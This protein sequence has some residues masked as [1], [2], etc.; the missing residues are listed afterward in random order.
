MD[1]FG[2]ADHGRRAAGAETFHVV[3]RKLAVVG[4]FAVVDAELLFQMVHALVGPAQHAGHV[5]ADLDVIVALRLLVEHI[6]E[7]HDAADFGRLQLQHFGQF[8]LR[9]DRAIAEF[10]LDHIEC[11]QDRR[12]L[13]SGRI[14][15]H[16][17]ANLCAD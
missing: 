10:T 13:A 4:L 14:E 15:V 8:V 9:L 7:A 16:P 3:E 1:L 12:A 11:G 6:I 2:D 5:G 17:R